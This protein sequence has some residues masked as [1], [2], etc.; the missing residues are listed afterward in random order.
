[1]MT[2]LNFLAGTPRSNKISS[3][4]YVLPFI[5]GNLKYPQSKHRRAD[6]NCSAISKD[7]LTSATISHPEESSVPLPVPGSGVEG[8]VIDETGADS[9]AII[10][11]PGE[12]NGLDSKASTGSLSDYTVCNG[13]AHPISASKTDGTEEQC[14]PR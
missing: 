3:S 14:T 12:S 2:S 7:R 4:R 11:D 5:S 8:V 13:L 10:P 9:D 6:P 1:M